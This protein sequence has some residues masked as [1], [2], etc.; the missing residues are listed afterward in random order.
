M[1]N[2][3]PPRRFSSDWSKALEGDGVAK[4]RISGGEPTLGKEH[5]LALLELV[6]GTDYLF[7]QETNGVLIGSN[8][9]YAHQLARYTKIHVRVSLKAGRAEGFEERT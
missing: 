4:L 5:L 9:D 3:I 8:A 2:Y 6:E 1:A 7:I